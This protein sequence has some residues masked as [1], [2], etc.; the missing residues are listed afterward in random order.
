[1]LINYEFQG[2]L[3]IELQPTSKNGALQD[4]GTVF[5]LFGQLQCMTIKRSLILICF[6]AFL[7]RGS[8]FF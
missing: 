6:S 7:N 3:K 1:M 4:N 5:E 8:V 2:F